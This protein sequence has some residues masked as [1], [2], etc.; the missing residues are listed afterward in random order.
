MLEAAA[1][2]LKEN[3][4]KIIHATAWLRSPSSA[5]FSSYWSELGPSSNS[6]S[7]KEKSETNKMDI[8]NDNGGMKSGSH[9]IWMCEPL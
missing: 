1:P 4:L 9:S 6:L 2:E 7:W 5:S 3:S 8:F